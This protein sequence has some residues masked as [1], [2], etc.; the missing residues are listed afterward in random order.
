VQISEKYIT[1]IAAII[2][3]LSRANIVQK[4]GNS[5]TSAANVSNIRDP[6]TKI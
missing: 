3:T 6:E 1:L 2:V 5:F 4:P